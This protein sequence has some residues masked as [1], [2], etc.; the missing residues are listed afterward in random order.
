MDEQSLNLNLSD[1]ADA[2]RVI[3]YAA[4][5]GAFRGWTNIRQIIALRDRLDIFV[6]A[7]SGDQSNPPAESVDALVTEALGASPTPP[8]PDF[9]FG[10]QPR[11]SE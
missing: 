2:V 4:D 9:V 8:P 5:Q 6:T 11:W 1:L 10:E 3:D 7:A